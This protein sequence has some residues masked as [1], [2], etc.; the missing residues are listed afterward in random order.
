MKE[1]EDDSGGEK[2]Q[3]LKLRTMEIDDLPQVFHLGEEL[4]KAEAVPSM[5]RTWDPYEVVGLFHSDNEFCLVA[6]IDD[7]I[8]GFALG[9]T[10]EKRHSA[11]KY[12]H[13][14]WLG[15]TP[16]LQ[17]K[18]VA[19]R[20]VRKFKDILLKHGVRMIIVDTPAENLPA[21]RFFRKFGFGQPRRH[22]YLSLNL[23]A[24]HLRLKQKENGDTPR[25]A[26]KNHG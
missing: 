1:R 4:F 22:I 19:E 12:G 21:L 3:G 26:P 24:E 20:L 17:R 8:V 10:I 14:I 11:W 23:A 13:L 16:V 18:G 7:A 25:R 6:E 2:R 9:T 15:V 5:Y